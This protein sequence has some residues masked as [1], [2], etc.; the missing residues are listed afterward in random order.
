MLPAAFGLFL[1]QIFAKLPQSCAAVPIPQL[2]RGTV[3]AAAAAT[4]KKTGKI[5][6]VI[7]GEV[8]N[9]LAF[10]TFEM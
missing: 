7:S 5:H 9:D 8:L 6:P 3:A 4:R 10:N 2:Q 1:C